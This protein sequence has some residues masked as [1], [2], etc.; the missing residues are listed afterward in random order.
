MTKDGLVA[1]LS[2]RCD[3]TKQEARQA[4]ETL[5]NGIQE[6]LAKG[7]RVSIVGFGAFEVRERA[8]R[9]GRNP[10]TGATLALPATRTPFF[11]PSQ[12]LRDMVKGR[13]R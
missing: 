7:E 11:L 13:A 5:I 9:Q 4:L 12:H 8:Q 3:M 6:S 1:L 2:R 10:Q